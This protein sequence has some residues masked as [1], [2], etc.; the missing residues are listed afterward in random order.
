MN[1]REHQ[2]RIDFYGQGF[3]LLAEA[4]KSVPRE[5]WK[6]KP[7]PNEWSVHETLIHLA[8]AE[9]N[10][11]M[12]ARKLAI[13]PGG[14]IMAYDHEKWAAELHYHEQN[15]DDALR[16]IQYTRL[17][18]YRWLKMLPDEVFSHTMKHPDYPCD[19]TFEMWLVVYSEHIPA[20]IE[21]IQ[22]T[23]E[24]WK[25]EQESAGKVEK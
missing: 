10:A 16:L 14:T 17:M 22:K 12:R 1:A 23:C 24:L 8:D 20:H 19:Y 7:A 9:T 5:M 21:Q 11:A 4:L 6:Y 13:E 3:E 15:P 25:K 2:V 18:T